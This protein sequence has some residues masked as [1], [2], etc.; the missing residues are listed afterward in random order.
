MGV[1]KLEF[2]LQKTLKITDSEILVSN[3]FLPVSNGDNIYKEPV[4]VEVDFFRKNVM[5]GSFSE[6]VFNP[7]ADNGATMLT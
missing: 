5:L 6:I 4:A 2:W 1:K 7:I 3:R